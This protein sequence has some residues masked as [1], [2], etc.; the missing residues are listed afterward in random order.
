MVF[1]DFF[2]NYSLVLHCN[3]FILKLY[4]QL[5][6]FQLLLNDLPLHYPLY[7]KL[8]Q[9]NYSFMVVV[10]LNFVNLFEVVS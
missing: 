7:A 6:F 9:L 1:L 4:Y 3:H 10:L 5:N 8:Y 2:K